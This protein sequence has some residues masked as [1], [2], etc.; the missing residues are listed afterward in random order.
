MKVEVTIVDVPLGTMIMRAHSDPR[1]PWYP[2]D[3][4]RV[5]NVIV[6]MVVREARVVSSWDEASNAVADS[7]LVQKRETENQAN[8]Q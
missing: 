3:V 4:V 1:D 5:G 8:D 6:A 2:L 7:E